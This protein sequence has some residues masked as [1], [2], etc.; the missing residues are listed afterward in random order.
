MKKHQLLPI[1][2]A[3]LLLASGSFAQI[4]DKT[5][6]VAKGAKVEKAA[7]GFNF[8]E[9]PAVAKNGDVYFTDQPNDHIHKWSAKDGK[10]S[11]F[12]EN[13]SRSNGTYF[14]KNGMLISCADLEN[15][16]L[17][18]GPDGKTEVLVTDYQGKKLNG[19]N[20]VWIA[21]NGTMY[22]TDPLYKRAWWK[23]SPEMQQD[24]EHVYMLS[25]DR[26]TFTRVADDLTK[27]N[28]II[29]TPD[30]KKLYVADIGAGKTYS[31][32]ILSDGSLA[33]KQLFAELGSD[34]MT[35]DT[36][37][38]IYL[39]GKGVTVFNPKGEQIAQIPIEERWTA[40]VVF[41]GKDRKTL[42]ITAMG[43]VYTLKMKVKGAY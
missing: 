30:G 33:N 28:G 35:I 4:E 6:I 34:G 36:K 20:D 10:V 12:M 8:T 41:G 14:D 26:K 19:P 24:G 32:D 13:T 21:P 2:L 9:G 38:N 39:T 31:F 5:S 40:N 1:C 3:G 22:V 37:G 18:I 25:A 43:S 42:F 27:P 7:D 15:E 17:A 11:L 29:G 16:L 23:R